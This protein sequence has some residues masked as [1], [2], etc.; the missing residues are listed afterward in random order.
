MNIPQAG[1]IARKL[2]LE[3]S[4]RLLKGKPMTFAVGMLSH[5]GLIVAADTQL[6]NLSG[7][8]E[9]ACKI[10]AGLTASGSYAIAYSADDRNAADSLLNEIT[11][12]LAM[13]DPKS[14]LGF[15]NAI[16]DAMETWAARYTVQ[17]DRPL[18]NLVVGA[19]VKETPPC[20]PKDIG[21]YFCE[22]PSTVVQ[23]TQAN[24]SGYVSTGAGQVVADPLFR[25][26]FFR[27]ASTHIR[28]AQIS[29]LM[30]R[31]KKDCG[32][33][34]GGETDAVYLSFSHTKPLWITNGSMKL[35][36]ARGWIVDEALMRA[37]GAI[38]SDQGT[39][40]RCVS[41]I[42]SLCDQFQD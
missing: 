31:A 36:E 7:I 15:E 39:E 35:A 8:T 34:C 10:Q 3:K 9:Y 41:E 21:L 30:Y 23:K 18:I 40:S 25:I 32:G 16:R 38:I 26:L 37:M 2:L 13:L 1:T 28:L 22:P 24:S 17:G 29:Y 27:P 5:G 4:K 20:N 42:D 19:F 11:D 12:D 14:L 6:T 33:F